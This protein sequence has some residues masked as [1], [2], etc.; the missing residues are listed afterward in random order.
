MEAERL[1]ALANR[2]QDLTQRVADLRRFL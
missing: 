2:L 1:N